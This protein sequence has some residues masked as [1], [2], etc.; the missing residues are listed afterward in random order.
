M[1]PPVQYDLDK[2]IWAMLGYAAKRLTQKPSIVEDSD[3]ED[4]RAAGW[5][6]QGAYEATALISLLLQWSDG[7]RFGAAGGSDTR[8]SAI[9]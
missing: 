8:R 1:Q 3:V 9:A 4:L 7:S 2:K 6:E 5:E